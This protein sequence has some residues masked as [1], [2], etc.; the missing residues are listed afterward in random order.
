VLYCNL[1][2][3]VNLIKI[4]ILII[5]GNDIIKNYIVKEMLNELNNAQFD[6]LMGDVEI[7]TH[8]IH[9]YLVFASVKYTNRDLDNINDLIDTVESYK[10]KLIKY[11]E[12][13][14][15]LEASAVQHYN[16]ELITNCEYLKQELLERIVYLEYKYLQ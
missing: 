16:G 7:L 13:L 9:A 15:D 5:K 1:L 14:N 3:N 6:S 11:V 12:K 8:K 4:K 2:E 10:D